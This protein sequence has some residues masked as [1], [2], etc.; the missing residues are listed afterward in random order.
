MCKIQTYGR[1][2]KITHL[3]IMTL[4]SAFYLIIHMM[5]LTFSLRN[6]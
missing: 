3:L 4:P 2:E 1:V 6:A 5:L